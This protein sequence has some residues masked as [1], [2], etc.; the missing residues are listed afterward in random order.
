MGAWLLRR[1]KSQTGTCVPS[2][3]GASVVG[4]ADV[5]GFGERLRE[6]RLQLGWTQQELAKR[7][8]IGAM[9][10]SNYERGVSKPKN[11][12]SAMM[13][14]VLGVSTAWLVFGVAA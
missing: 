7:M 6:R 9:E 2:A 11:E 3:H 14:Q 13:A 1:E 8:N 10:V 5:N 4:M 12:R